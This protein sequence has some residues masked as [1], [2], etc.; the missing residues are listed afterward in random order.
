MMPYQQGDLENLCGLYALINAARLA[1][2]TLE[3][4]ECQDVYLAA[5]RWLRKRKGF[6]GVLNEGMAINTVL[7]LHKAVFQRQWP[8]MTLH[9]AF[10]RKPKNAKAFW[11]RMEKE[12]SRAN[13]GMF[14]GIGGR[15]NHWSAVHKITDKTIRLFDSGELSS[16]HRRLCGYSQEQDI[17]YLIVPGHVLLLRAA[18]PREVNHD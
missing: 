11:S 5:L 14:I 1:D 12:A 4:K 10:P 2:P 18:S 3:Y 9:R 15:Y 7:S 13:Q 16:L 6:L 8:Q 17:P